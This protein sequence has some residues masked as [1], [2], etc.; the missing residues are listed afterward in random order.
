[1]DGKGRGVV[2][3]RRVKGM[4]RREEGKGSGVARNEGYGY[5]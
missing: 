5:C 1:M 2:T 4:G 3:V